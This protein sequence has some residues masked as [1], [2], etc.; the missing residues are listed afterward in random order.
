MEIYMTWEN[1]QIN[2]IKHWLKV[3]QNIN[4]DF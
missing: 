2:I 4:G 3:V 1:G